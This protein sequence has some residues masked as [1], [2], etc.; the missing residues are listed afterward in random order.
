[1]RR[2]L[3]NL[4]LAIVLGGVAYCIY[5]AQVHGVYF[6]DHVVRD[7]AI[8]ASTILIL[9]ILFSSGSEG[10][11]SIPKKYNLT[12][13]EEDAINTGISY[14]NSCPRNPVFGEGQFEDIQFDF[15][16]IKDE[17]ERQR[18]NNK[19]GLEEPCVLEQTEASMALRSSEAINKSKVMHR[20][21]VVQ[22]C[23][24]KDRG[25][26]GWSKPPH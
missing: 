10:F 11:I 12:Q 25:Y 21:T 17:I 23:V 7:I 26:A 15:S 9:S 14:D 20:D 22:T 4:L 24:G 6:D 8:V 3:N 16:D 5:D 19:G 1:M 13:I 2:G 18:Y